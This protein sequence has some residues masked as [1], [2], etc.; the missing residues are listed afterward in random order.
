M[1]EDVLAS[2]QRDL[3]NYRGSGMSV[4]EMSHRGPDYSAIHDK[5]EADLRALLDVPEG[6]SVLFLQGGASLQFGALPLNL[7]ARGDP[8]DYVVTGSWSKKAAAEARKFN[9][10]VHVTEGDN[11]SIPEPAEWNLSD[12]AAYVHICSNETIQGVEFPALPDLGDKV[13]CADMSSN[14]CS[15]PV[16]VSRYGVIYAGAQKNI[17]PSG[18]AIVIVRDDLLDRARPE[19][20]VMMHYKTLAEA[21]SLYNTPNCWGIYL[22]G[23]VFDKLLKMGGLEEVEKLNR[24]KCAVVYDAI[25]GSGGFYRC[26]VEP[27]FRSA[28]NVPFTIP[29]SA[30]LEKAFVEESTA[31]GLANLKGHRS[32]GGMVS[33]GVGVGCGRRRGNSCLTRP[34]PPPPARQP[35]QR[36]ADGG[37]RHPGALHEGF[38]GAARVESFRG[39]FAPRHEGHGMGEEVVLGG[40]N[41]NDILMTVFLE[42]HM[43]VHAASP[44]RS[45][46]KGTSISGASG[47]RYCGAPEAATIC[48]NSSWSRSAWVMSSRSCMLVC[49]RS[50][51]LR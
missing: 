23:M 33:M 42:K 41:G 24:A 39:F 47:F 22:C 51:A 9:D 15:K 18:L 14:F 29:A 1:Y 5:A 7:S 45:H 44:D 19:T 27:T 21:R 16:D 50:L 20:P 3:V 46:R 35:V 30:D 4:M 32:V 2:A 48:S 49:I 25:A 34:T 11:V 43:G 12:E 31:A 8:V 17:G 40:S 36:H 37:R 26:P 28:M 6:Y 10:T 38:P 13:L